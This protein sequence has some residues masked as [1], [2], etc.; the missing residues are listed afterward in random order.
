MDQTGFKG[1]L[2]SIQLCLYRIPIALFRKVDTHLANKTSVKA[3]RHP[4]SRTLKIVHPSSSNSN[5]IIR[6]SSGAKNNPILIDEEDIEM[7]EPSDTNLTTTVLNSIS[8]KTLQ[9]LSILVQSEHLSQLCLMSARYSSTCQPHLCRLMVS[10]I[11]LW[12]TS[13]ETVLNTLIYMTPSAGPSSRSANQ[14][15]GF[16]KELWRMSVRPG[17]ISVS[18][19]DRKSGG[20]PQGVL[21]TL[22]D[23][24]LAGQWEDLILLCELYSRYLMTLGDE[25]FF[26]DEAE[27]ASTL[28]FQRAKTSVISTSRNPLMTDEVVT[29][30]GLLRNLAFGLYW[31]EGQADIKKGCVV[32]THVSLEYL[33][34]LATRLLQ[35]IYIRE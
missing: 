7:N 4:Q 22:K 14:S 26:D 13:K 29:L 8:P 10:I 32:G 1:Y 16:I 33:R 34:S 27:V 28:S 31:T 21:T 17:K 12:P 6:E 2:N 24:K 25:E 11:Y 20:S 5:E 18:L 19:R 15:G 30:A 35:Q 23:S 9:W 3:K